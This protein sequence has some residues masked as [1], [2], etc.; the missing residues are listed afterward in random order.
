MANRETFT[1]GIVGR[2]N[3]GKST[4]FNKLTKSRKAIV[5]DMPGVTRDRMFGRADLRG[6]PSLII[7]TGGIDMTPE[8]IITSQIREQAHLGIE[9]ADVICLV[10]DGKAGVTPVD[11]QIG[12]ILRKS[13]KRVIVAVNKLDTPKQEHEMAEFFSLGFK[14]VLP[15]S[16]EHSHGFYELESALIEGRTEPAYEEAKVV[17]KADQ[18]FTVAVLGRP[19]V[20]KSSLINRVLGEKRLMVSDI[21][22]TTRDAVDTSVKWH[23]KEF[24]FIDTAGIRRKNRVSQKIEKYSIIMSIKSIERAQMALLVLDATQGI[25]TQDERVA[26]LILAERRACIIVVNKWDLMEKDSNS[27]VKFEQDLEYKL[28]FLSWAPVVF[29]SALTG[30]RMNKIFEEIANVRDEFRK[31]LDTGPLNRKLQHWTGKQPPPIV[32]GHRVKFFFVSQAESPPPTFNFVVSRTG[33]VGESYERYLVNRIREEYGFSGAPI[34]CVYLPRTGR[35][36]HTGRGDAAPTRRPASGSKDRPRRNSFTGPRKSGAEA[37]ET[38]RGDAFAAPRKFG[39]EAKETPRKSNF[40]SP[41]KSAVSG[42]V[43]KRVK[44]GIEK[45]T[46]SNGRKKVE[47]TGHQKH[48]R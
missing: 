48:K 3:V 36:S 29:V 21:P 8:D 25:T 18:P 9:E 37:R 1:V 32:K 2:P 26:G 47:R 15:I 19:N 4:L 43:N 44:P 40:K 42:A 6:I 45:K 22:G 30:Q 28:K 24:V 23:G 20:G 27:T 33:H 39:A 7:D 46:R 35:H 10:V 13:G 31:H 16:A 38:P 5:D 11:R 14:E 34:K 12:E 17:A 41:R